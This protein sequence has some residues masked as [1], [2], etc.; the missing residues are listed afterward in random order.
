MW[1][2]R[3]GKAGLPKRASLIVVNE[4]ALA[5]ADLLRNELAQALKDA[6]DKGDERTVSTLRLVLTA[7]NERDHCARDGGHVSGIDRDA[8]IDMLKEMVAQR[9]AEIDRCESGARLDVAEQEAEEIEVLERFLP[10]QMSREEITEAVES[11]IADMDAHKLKDMGPVLSAL[12]ERYDGTLDVA[13]A[14]QILCDRL[15]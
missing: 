14:R 10:V 13:L 12:K 11:A 7:I 6:A 3:V 2:E 5:R 9:R 8:I 1:Y 15:S 4:Q